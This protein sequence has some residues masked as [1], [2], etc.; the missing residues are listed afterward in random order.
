MSV[1]WHIWDTL[2]SLI[3]MAQRVPHPL[4]EVVFNFSQIGAIVGGIHFLISVLELSRYMGSLDLSCLA[5]TGVLASLCRSNLA[6]VRVGTGL[7]RAEIIPKHFLVPVQVSAWQGRLHLQTLLFA[8][9]SIT[10]A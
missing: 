2:A 9:I 4:G 6:I 8:V 1:M 10:L 3:I 5:Q 7:H